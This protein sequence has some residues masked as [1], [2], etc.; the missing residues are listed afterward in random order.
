MSNIRQIVSILP[1]ILAVS[2]ALTVQNTNNADTLAKA[3][4]GEGIKLVSASF[5]GSSM[6]SGT[7]TAGPQGIRNAGVLTTGDVQDVIPDPATDDEVDSKSDGADGADDL[8][9][10]LAD[11]ATS[12]DATVLSMEVELSDGFDGFAAEFVFATEEYPE[13]VGSAYNDVFGIFVDSKQV[14]FDASGAPITV[15]GPFFSSNNVITPPESGSSYQG[16]TPLLRSGAKADPGAH[17]IDIAICDISDTLRD[18]S[19][20]V[21]INACNGDKCKSGTTI[22]PDDEK[23]PYPV[24][25]YPSASGTG[26]PGPGYGNGTHPEPCVTKTYTACK[27][28]G[29]CETSYEVVTYPKPTYPVTDYPPNTYPPNTYPVT[30]YE[31]GYTSSG[32]EY[33]VPTYSTHVPKPPAYPPGDTPVEYQPPAPQYTNGSLPYQQYTVGAAGRGL[34]VAAVVAGLVAFFW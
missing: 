20:F 25:P 5:K 27:Y 1:A 22:I 7:F 24:D 9:G 12:Y 26:Y 2:S 10:P 8:C 34:S 33:P 32:G 23:D 29:A 13:Y 28:D 21:A 6:S 16:S 4:L 15:N 11:G 14:A 30:D 3:I 17:H 18:S 19:V 31:P